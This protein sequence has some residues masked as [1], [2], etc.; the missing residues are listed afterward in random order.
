MLRSSPYSLSCVALACCFG[1]HAAP[2]NDSRIASVTVDPSG[3][4]VQRVA[5]VAAGQK[6]LVLDCVRE[7]IDLNTLQLQAKGDVRLGEVKVQTLDRVLLPE[8]G[9]PALNQQIRELEV[10]IEQLD[11]QNAAIDYA[12]AFL[13][14]GAEDSKAPPR[15]APPSP[16]A[17]SARQA[18]PAPVPG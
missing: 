3:A 4:T 15:A 12:L 17:V 8:C 6:E 1:A 11:S 16:K 10:Q 14:P 2:G 5:K 9:N 18:M 13:R 7:A